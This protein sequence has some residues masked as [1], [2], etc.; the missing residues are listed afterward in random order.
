MKNVLKFIPFFLMLSLLTFSCSED[1]ADSN[2]TNNCTTDPAVTVG[3]NIIGTWVVGGVSSE[4]VTFNANGTGFSS[5]GSFY[6][7]TTN[8]DKEYNNF[9]WVMAGPMTVLVTYNY[10]T[11]TPVVPYI[12]SENFT[13][14]LNNCDRIE[15]EDAWSNNVELTR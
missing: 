12:I 2:N 5:P 8:N 15:M 7:A 6:F 11:D 14:T 4:T 3:E 9:D 13:A 10:G 1:E